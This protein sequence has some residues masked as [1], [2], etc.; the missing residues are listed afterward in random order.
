MTS[1]QLDI[2][3]FGTYN[4][5]IPLL[6]IWA[7]GVLQSSHS[8]SSNG[9]SNSWTLSYSGSAPSS[10]YFRFNDSSNETGRVIDIQSVQINDRHITTQN[11]LILDSLIKNQS[12]QLN[13]TA[14]TPLF[15][16][17]E[18]PASVFANPT[19]ALTSGNDNVRDMD[20]C[21]GLVLNG[22]GGR[23]LFLLSDSE[24]TI[25][26]GAGDDIIRGNGGDDLL[27]G[28]S[29][30]DRIY[31]GNDGDKLYGGTG[32]DL[33]YGEAGN[34]EIHG[35]D[36]DD[37]INGGAGD[38]IMTGG[39]GAD[40]LTGGGG[41]NSMYGDSG[42]DQM[43]G[44]TG[45]DVM[46]GGADNDLLYGGNGNDILYGGDGL[47]TLVGDLGD[48]QL[49][50]NDGIDKLYGRAGADTLEGGAGD[51]LLYGG[52]GLDTISG[53]AG[54][55]SFIFDSRYAFNDIDLI[56]D[57]DPVGDD[58]ILDISDLLDGYTGLINNYVDFQ[59]VGGNT[60]VR[61]DSDGLTGGANFQ[62]I[63]TLEDVTGLNLASLYLSGNIIA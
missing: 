45:A 53:G 37:K 62:T 23:D 4:T 30:N 51:D 54:A 60:N 21:G 55:D 26:G 6:E 35:G 31:G 28:D 36:G 43:I 11:Y 52:D 57:F 63:A 3:A 32:N 58:D 49:F 13:I 20:G 41:S 16:S 46:D 38:D 47:D 2:T 42:N 15:S 9:F 61:V 59:E 17:A 12:S 18:P 33:L 24:D 25:N 48:D 50:G 7:E 40:K 8:I 1:Y 56:T 29:G 19:Y 14:A 10:L 22:L 5:D 27:F 34:D 39:A 44:G